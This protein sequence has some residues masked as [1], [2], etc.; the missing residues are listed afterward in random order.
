[1]SPS[2]PAQR[3]WLMAG[4]SL[5]VVCCDL[6]LLGTLEQAEVLLSRVPSCTIEVWP[7]SLLSC[8]PGLLKAVT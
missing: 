4:G 6:E 3:R 8:G 7:E 5:A 1:M 2:L